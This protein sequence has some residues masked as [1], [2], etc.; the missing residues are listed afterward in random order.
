M[1]AI[2]HSWGQNL[3]QHVHLHCI[4]PGGALS[5]DHGEWHP[6]RS[7]YLFPVK[8]LSR[9]FRAKM[10]SGLRQAWQAQQLSRV[11]RDDVDGMLNQ[12]MGKDWV[13]YSKATL[14]R[15]QTVMQYLSRYTHKIAISNQR[16]L[17]M[18]DEHVL[19]RW[20]DYRDGKEKTM[21]LA[22]EEFVR[23][24]LLHILPKGLMRIRHYGFLAN[25]CRQQ[26]LRSLRQCLRQPPAEP[27]PAASHQKSVPATTPCRCP[28]CHHNALWVRT[29]IAPKRVARGKLP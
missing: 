16:L 25:R 10:V 20:H 19:F 9:V 24:F 23:R 13:V 15:A 22:G 12:L 5:H 8:A 4:L 2:L 6:A 11:T 28:R 14:R 21:T 29:E 1:T 27:K 18:D 17:A 3:S 26:K 7:T